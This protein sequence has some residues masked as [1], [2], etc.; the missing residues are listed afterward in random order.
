MRKLFLGGFIGIM[1]LI[2]VTPAHAGFGSGLA[3]GLIL[4]SMMSNGSN[5]V[6]SGSSAGDVIYAL[7]YVSERVTDPLG[8][9]MICSEKQSF[10]KTSEPATYDNLGGQTLRAIFQ[11][12]VKDPDKYEILQVIRIIDPENTYRANLW[13]SYIEKEK[14]TPLDKLPLEKKV[15]KKKK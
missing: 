4:S 3:T 7:P 13:F 1:T 15:E 12:K 5:T 11:G 9:R 10:N 2:S 14:V 8:V 6:V